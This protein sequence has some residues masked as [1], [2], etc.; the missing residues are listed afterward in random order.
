MFVSLFWLGLGI[1]G[2]YSCFI[3][4]N[5]FKKIREFTDSRWIFGFLLPSSLFTIY[6]LPVAVYTLANG[7][8]LSTLDILVQ[9]GGI[10]GITF[11]PYIIAGQAVNRI[12]E[13]NDLRRSLSSTN[14]LL[15]SFLDNARS[16]GRGNYIKVG[17][18]P[19]TFI[20]IIHPFVFPFSALFARLK[21]RMSPTEASYSEE[22]GVETS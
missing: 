21:A 4:F 8:G 13:W 18:F 5:F 14:F 20:W 22:G 10:W 2:V 15:F 7:V 12:P 9:Y 16:G 1:V 11:I 19:T 3:W 17:I 6:T